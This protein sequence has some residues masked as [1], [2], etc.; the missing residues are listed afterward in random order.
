MRRFFANGL[1]LK[2]FQT[3]VTS[4]KK[5]VILILKVFILKKKEKRG[6]DYPKRKFF[7]HGKQLQLS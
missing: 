4:E 1:I 6:R 5:K 7:K 3:G 2:T